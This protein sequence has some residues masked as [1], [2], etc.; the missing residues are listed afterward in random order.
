MRTPVLLY[1]GEC[2]LCARSVQFVLTHERPTSNADRETHSGALR[3]APLQGRF[4]TEV[5]RVHP[6]L[7]SIDSVVWFVPDDGAGSQLLVHSDATLAIFSYL[8]GMGRV[9]AGIGRMVPK[10]LRDALYRRVARRRHSLFAAACLLPTPA[11][12]ARF[13][14]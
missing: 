6:L 12:R 5:R 10:P 4:A 14:D 13:V 11:Q 9:L 7:H 8:G 2:G 1:D 3:F